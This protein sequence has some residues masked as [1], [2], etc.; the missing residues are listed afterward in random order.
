MKEVLRAI[1]DMSLSNKG[2]IANRVGVQEST[3]ESILSLLSWKGY[4]K[5]IDGTEEMPT[6]CIGCS[7]TKE[8]M[9]A[10]GAGSVYTITEKGK[11]YLEKN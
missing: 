8:C 3:L 2:D 10:A 7:I 11:R 5:T 1:N 6:Y 4:L 9:A